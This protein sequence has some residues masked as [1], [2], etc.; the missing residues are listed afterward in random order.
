MRIREIEIRNFRSLRHIKLENLGDFVIFIGRNGSGKSNILE[1]L[2]LFFADLNLTTDVEKQATP[3]L[4]F[5]KRTNTPIDMRVVLEVEKAEEWDG[6]DRIFS[7][8][9]LA[10]LK[11]DTPPQQGRKLTIRRQI[12]GKVWKNVEITLEN[13]F[14][15]ADGKIVFKRVLTNVPQANPEGTP[16]VVGVQ[17]S[18]EGPL[19]P[20]AAQALLKCL[21]TELKNQFK[22]IRGPRES[23]E[24]PAAPARAAILDAESKTFFTTLALEKDRAKE[25]LWNEYADDFERFSGRRLQV[26]GTEIEFRHRDLALPLEFSGSGDQALLILMRQFHQ[27]HKYFYGME[28]PETRLH[29][30]YIR[31]LFKYLRRVAGDWQIFVATHSPVF[32]DKAF[33]NN[34]WLTRCEG[35]Q[36]KVARLENDQL[37][38]VLFELGIRPSDFFFANEVLFVEGRS[39]EVFIPS[40]VEKARLD[41]TNVKIMPLRG[42]SKSKYHLSV[43]LEAAK[44]AGIPAF[45]LLDKNAQAEAEEVINARKV[46]RDNCKILDKETLR[47]A[48]DCDIEDLYP[49]DLLKAA[50]QSF[51]PEINLE[52]L[53]LNEDEPVVSKITAALNGDGWKARVASYVG[54]RLKPEHIE[55][56]FRD[57]VGFLRRIPDTIQ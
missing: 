22:M 57:V 32:V 51:Y 3:E 28:E 14:H 34:T 37:R 35:K 2:E 21:T 49:K 15:L 5:D 24:R 1:A 20:E 47:A 11:L 26:R 52:K 48:R 54:D 27:P 4:W 8:E 17:V 42:K 41:F 38:E 13:V 40:L 9:V 44:D 23:T 46:D 55:N 29:H 12:V 50:L 18:T 45:L 16:A 33:L 7:K 25:E 56:E 10:V 36:T 30:D 31:K 6:L 43:W 53:T 39:E 19:E